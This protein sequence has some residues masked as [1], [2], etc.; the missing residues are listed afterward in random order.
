MSNLIEQNSD[1][2]KLQTITDVLS[3]DLPSQEK[4]ALITSFLFPGYAT[5]SL[6][7]GEY[8]PDLTNSP[9]LQAIEK[10]TTSLPFRG[11]L[12][13]RDRNTLLLLIQETG[14]TS[15]E[16][17]KVIAFYQ[18][19]IRKEPGYDQK[20]WYQ[21]V[22]DAFGYFLKMQGDTWVRNHDWYLPGESSMMDMPRK[23]GREKIRHPDIMDFSDGE[24]V[25]W[26]DASVQQIERWTR[27]EFH[28]EPGTFDWIGL[29]DIHEKV[30]GSS[31]GFGAVRKF[32]ED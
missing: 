31:V 2:F 6:E 12:S 19:K 10:I 20:M 25:R 11:S 26:K 27:E 5:P 29:E 13:P 7:P 16:V 28:R 17:D 30:P 3:T 22:N 9:E 24:S 4:L 32:G 8:V 18:N 23:S 14:G 15:I 1:E 21:V